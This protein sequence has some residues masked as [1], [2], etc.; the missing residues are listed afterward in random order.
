[1]SLQGSAGRQRNYKLGITAYCKVLASD[2]TVR[3]K[4]VITAGGHVFGITSQISL[5]VSIGSFEHMV[6]AFV[7][8][9]KLDM[10]LGRTWFK[11]W[12]P[13]PTS[14]EHDEWTI[15]TKGQGQNYRLMLTPPTTPSAS[16]ALQCVKVISR[17]QFERGTQ[18]RH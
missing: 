6:T 12:Q 15:N 7:F 17:R 5:I 11:Q 2:T 13:A 14:W 8:D 10:I 16:P 3:G 9:I 1:M 4:E 18:G